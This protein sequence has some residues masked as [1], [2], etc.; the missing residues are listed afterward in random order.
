MAWTIGLWRALAPR[1][2]KKYFFIFPPLS[3]LTIGLW[4]ALAPD[5]HTLEDNEDNFDDRT[6]DDNM[7]LTLV[8]NGDNFDERTNDYNMTIT[9]LMRMKPILMTGPIMTIW[10][11]WSMMTVWSSLFTSAVAETVGLSPILAKVRTK[12]WLLFWYL[13]ISHF[14]QQKEKQKNRNVFVNCEFRWFWLEIW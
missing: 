12:R 8:E 4:Q 2:K 14:S 11:N 7:T 1:N 10:S 3:A 9:L 13:D 6:N 5:H